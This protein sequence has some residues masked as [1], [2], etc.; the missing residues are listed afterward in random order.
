MTHFK[1]NLPNEYDVV[2]D[3]LDNHLMA[4][5]DNVL[6]INMICKKLNHQ[7]EK[8]KSKKEEKSE[9]EKASGAYNKYKQR[10]HTCGKYGHKPGN[11]KFPKNK[12]EWDESNKKTE[13]NEDK[14]KKLME[15]VVIVAER[16]IWIGTVE[17]GNTAIIKYMRK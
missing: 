1:N 5:G 15:Y 8:I 17:K 10:C 3:G 11:S 4:T 2:L 6:T 12:S 16:G 7:Y 13:N 9:K 14:N